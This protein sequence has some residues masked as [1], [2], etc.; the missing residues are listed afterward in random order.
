MAN[1]HLH[2]LSPIMGSLD[3]IENSTI[4]SIRLRCALAYK[5][6]IA[7]GFT[8]TAGEYLPAHSDAVLVS[9][10]G[11]HDIHN[12]SIEW[13]NILKS[14]KAK[15][16]KIFI[17]YTDHHLGFDSPMRFFYESALSTA[18][19]FIVSS[20]H[21]KDNLKKFFQGPIYLIEDPIEV[22]LIAPKK[23]GSIQ[24]ILWFGHSTNVKYLIDFMVN[25]H[26]IRRIDLLVLTNSSGI[27][28]LQQSKLASHPMINLVCHDWSVDNLLSL[29][30]LSD[31]CIIP[32]DIN[33][34]KK[35]GASSNRLLTALSLGLP[36]VASPLKSYLDFSE[37]FIELHDHLN[38]DQL[39]DFQKYTDI[40]LKAHI[41]I[42]PKYSMNSIGQS[43]VELLTS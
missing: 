24:K 39:D 11:G 19:A 10:I 2:I 36:T 23:L 25:F 14:L 29:A 13:I 21:M 4:A 12:R 40:I 16:C 27:N 5:H 6:M 42:L 8:V 9:K 1:R 43:W 38:I 17:D 7:H 26:S 18:D 30:S 28:L 32:S 15:R 3:E 41:C 34:P 37:Y 35:N 33:D 31:I 22:P 20:L